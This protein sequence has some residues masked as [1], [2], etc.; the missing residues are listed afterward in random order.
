M[1]E[2]SHTLIQYFRQQSRFSTGEDKMTEI[3]EDVRLYVGGMPMLT[4]L[5]LAMRIDPLEFIRGVSEFVTVIY[6]VTV[7]FAFPDP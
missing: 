7:T 6:D 5:C 2:L 3:E 1:R 4:V